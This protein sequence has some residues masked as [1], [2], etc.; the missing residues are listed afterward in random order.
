[1]TYKYQTRGT[2]S[3][4]IIID[5]TD[6]GVVSDVKFEGGCDGN[7]NGMSRLVKGR[8]AEEIIPLLEGIPCSGKPTSCPDQLARALKAITEQSGEKA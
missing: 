2:C 4:M 3:R 7:L 8:T 1:M 6:S 5:I